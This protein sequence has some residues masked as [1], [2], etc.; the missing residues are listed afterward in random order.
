MRS[1]TSLVLAVVYQS[2]TI[3][4][5]LTQFNE[6]RMTLPGPSLKDVKVA[7]DQMDERTR[8]MSVFGL[9]RALEQGRKVPRGSN[10]DVP[11]TLMALQVAAILSGDFRITFGVVRQWADHPSWNPS[12]RLACECGGA[13]GLR[14]PG[15]EYG[16]GCLENIHHP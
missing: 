3:R 1:R 7:L 14:E 5:P 11:V 6:A 12:W 16:M 13:L 8:Q 9:R 2:A 4:I 10:G 15:D